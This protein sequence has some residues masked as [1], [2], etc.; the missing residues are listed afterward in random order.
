M[1]LRI[2]HIAVLCSTALTVACPAPDST[3]RTEEPAGDVGCRR[4]V[5]DP[6]CSTHPPPDVV[7]EI[8]AIV[9]GWYFESRSNR[10]CAAGGLACY[11]GCEEAYLPFDTLEECECACILCCDDDGGPDPGDSD[12]N[13]PM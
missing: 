11:E 13:Q 6:R 3:E 10:C 4:E 8:S 9:I 12:D 7:D 2:Q 1:A 5:L